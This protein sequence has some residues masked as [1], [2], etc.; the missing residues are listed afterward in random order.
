MDAL[1]FKQIFLPLS[2]QL[3]AVALRL[4][5][6]RQA[7]ED[8]VQDT[9]LRLWMKRDNLPSGF[10]PAGYSMVTLRN[11]FLDSK[12]RRGLEET[13][14]PL[15]RLAV[16]NDSQADSD[17]DSNDDV[18][19]V[20]QLISKLPPKQRMVITMHDIEG[21]DSE[22]IQRVTGLTDINIR[23]LLSRARSTVRQQFKKLSAYEDR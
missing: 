18:A 6:N 19:L 20:R 11:I 14:Q 1:K 17:A 4:T 16:V 12:R 5:G 2:S 21:L 22:E 13:D 8:L 3:Y 9:L 23:T 15:E 7:A 10:D